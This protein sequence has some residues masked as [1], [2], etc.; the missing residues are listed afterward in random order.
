MSPDVPLFSAGTFDIAVVTAGQTSCATRRLVGSVTLD[1]GKRATVVLMGLAGQDSGPDALGVVA[2]TDEP[3]D[4]LSAR[5]R[6]IHAALGASSQPAIGPLLVIAAGSVIAP[7]VDPGMTSAPS[8]TRPPVDA[9]GYA[10]LSVF[11]PP[12]PLQ[13]DTL[14]DATAIK[15]VTAE[16]DLAVQEGTSHTGIILTLGQGALGVAWCG[17]GPATPGTP[18]CS[19]LLAQ[20]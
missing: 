20:P 6:M 19:L 13:L 16:R 2:F 14:G 8:M 18:T 5:V 17:D 11:D 10:T 3:I 1:A 9:L 7:E 4:P 15:W 12:T